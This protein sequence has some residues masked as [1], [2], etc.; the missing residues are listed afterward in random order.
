MARDVWDPKIT[1]PAASTVWK[2]GS[3]VTVTWDTSDAPQYPTSIQGKIYLGHMSDGE[4]N[5]HL[6]I[7]HPLAQGVN[8][9]KGSAQVTVP[10]DVNP[11]ADYIIVLM[12]DSGNRSQKFTIQ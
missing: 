4:T 1:S 12:G 9:N 10:A 7:N 3:M 2:R 11:G 8:L 5:E 6:D